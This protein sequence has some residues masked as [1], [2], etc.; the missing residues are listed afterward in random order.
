MIAPEELK[1]SSEP[2]TSAPP[3]Q[4]WLIFRRSDQAAVALLLVGALI[5]CGIFLLKTSSTSGNMT[6]VELDDAGNSLRRSVPYLVDINSADVAELGELP[7]VGPN[8]ARRI[9]EHRELHGPF[10]TADDLLRVKG[11][12][13]KTL[14]ALRPH[15]RFE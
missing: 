15:V 5:W 4:R 13:P 9:I 7:Q 12:G 1:S 14:A 6:N 2:A 10:R 8:L 3:A 11:I